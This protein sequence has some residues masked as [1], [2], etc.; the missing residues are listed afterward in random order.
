MLNNLTERGKN[1]LEKNVQFW[2]NISLRIFTN[3]WWQEKVSEWA[4]SA[5][6]QAAAGAGVHIRG[7]GGGGIHSPQLLWSMSKT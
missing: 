6:E 7:S 3:F 5:T 4:L 1:V 2:A